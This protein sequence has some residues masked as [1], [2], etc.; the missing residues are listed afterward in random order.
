M[1][2][3]TS[4]FD[5]SRLSWHSLADAQGRGVGSLDTGSRSLMREIEDIGKRVVAGDRLLEEQFAISLRQL[6][7]QVQED[8]HRERLER[9]AGLQ[10]VES[11]VRQVQ[12]AVGVLGDTLRGLELRIADAVPGGLG[13]NRGVL[14]DLEAEMLRCREESRR[15][16]ES[17][18]DVTTSTARLNTSVHRCVE[19][20]AVTRA[21]Q[22]QKLDDRLEAL[23]A[24]L[25]RSCRELQRQMSDSLREFA[26]QV[27]SVEAKAESGVHECRAI[28]ASTQEEV[29][30]LRLLWKNSM[31]V[32]EARAASKLLDASV[33]RRS[34][35]SLRPPFADYNDPQ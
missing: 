22:D 31:D 21:E 35:L 32:L 9:D 30:R 5:A 10:R 26:Q 34:D 25:D 12:E 28:G 15:L 18:G 13:S 2:R 11:F 17:L 14:A 8:I 33:T 20:E 6:N 19:R 7:A 29:N 4:A 3:G 1:D 24:D 23:A 27:G 16:A